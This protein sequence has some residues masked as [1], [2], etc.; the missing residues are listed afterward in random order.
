MGHKRDILDAILLDVEDLAAEWDASTMDGFHAE[1]GPT[2]SAEAW[3]A[4][5]VAAGKEV[6]AAR[7]RQLLSLSARSIEPIPKVDIAP[8]LL[9]LPREALL[10]RVQALCAQ[11]REVQ[12]AYRNLRRQSD[13]DLRLLITLL[14]SPGEQES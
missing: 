6:L 3:A 9:S 2:A 12:F 8:H 4:N 1:P 14:E 7:R 5:E 13:D 10:A 11:P